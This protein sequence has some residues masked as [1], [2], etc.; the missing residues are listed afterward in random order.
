MSE[1]DTGPHEGAG[2]PFNKYSL[3]YFKGRTTVPISLA[4]I[5]PLLLTLT[6]RQED[7]RK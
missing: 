3:T 1:G 6:Y 5:L 2:S 4:A 7:R